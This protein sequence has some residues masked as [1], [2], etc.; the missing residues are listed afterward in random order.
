MTSLPCLAILVLALLSTNAEDTAPPPSLLG[1]PAPAFA[2]IPAIAPGGRPT[3]LDLANVREDV[4]VV[5]F[6]AVHCPV[7]QIYEGR[8]NRFVDAYRKRSV[9][10]IGVSVADGHDDGLDAIRLYVRDKKSRYDYGHDV[11][12]RLGRAFGATTTP[13]CFVLDRRRVVRYIGA[14]DD[15]LNEEGVRRPYLREA[16]DALLAGK[17]IPTATTEV[18]G[19][20]IDYADEPQP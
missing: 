6:L 3:T 1:K 14:I 7:V 18:V 4:V 20:P 2:G 10:V 5:V 15:D 11:S 13:Q 17:T 12:Q 19:C 9:K 16:V 8:L